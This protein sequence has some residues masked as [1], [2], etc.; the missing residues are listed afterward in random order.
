MGGGGR[1]DRVGSSVVITSCREGE[2]HSL[3]E[4]RN[5]ALALTAGYRAV[6]L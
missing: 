2:R 3:S 4:I 5:M 1:V 6:L